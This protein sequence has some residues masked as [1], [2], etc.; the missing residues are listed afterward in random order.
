MQSRDVH[1]R[2]FV[3][4][5]FGLADPPAGREGTIMKAYAVEAMGRDPAMADLSD[6]T[7]GDG[8]VLLRVVACG[9]NFADLLMA[10]GSY[11]EAPKPPFALGMEISGVVEA[12]GPGVHGLAPGD[13]VFAFPGRGGLAERAAL[14][15]ERCLPMPNGVS[16][17]QAAAM[18]VAYGTSELALDRGRLASGETILVLGAAGGVGLAAVELAAAR[19]ATVIACARGEAK[20]AAAL[21]VGAH[22]A[23]DAE[24]DL[25][26]AVRALG[27]ADVVF[28]PVGGPLGEAALRTLRPLGRHL[29]IGFAAGGP[30]ALKANHLLV[31]NVDVVGVYWGG[32]SRFAPERLVEGLRRVADAVAE[33]TL[34]PRVETVLPL[35]R[36]GEGLAMLRERRATGKVVVQVSPE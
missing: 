22:H 5:R 23:V 17:V 12:A 1:R 2:S 27:G 24:D 11:Q 29:V 10:E 18:Q 32:Y 19:G 4:L 6:P 14:P 31:K 13:R 35:E 26:H 34:R 21:E 9:L 16:M 3:A 36:A 15:A 20:R 8:E 28:D 7:P 30:P 25:R 33:G